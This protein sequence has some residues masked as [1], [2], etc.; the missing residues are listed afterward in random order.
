MP[1]K[2]KKVIEKLEFILN[3]MYGGK[4]LIQK[5]PDDGLFFLDYIAYT[6]S[7]VDLKAKLWLVQKLPTRQCI[8]HIWPQLELIFIVIA[9]H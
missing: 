9:K 6:Q 7:S 4:S 1:K 2:T 8:Q 5:E 3:G